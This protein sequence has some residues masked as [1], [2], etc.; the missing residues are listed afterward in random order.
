MEY[1]VELSFRARQELMEAWKWYES[2]QQ[3]LGNR[4]ETEVYN[5][6]EAIQQY[7][8]RFPE[9]IQF[10]REKHIR[11]FPYLIIYRVI[12]ENNI[13]LISSIFHTRRNPETKG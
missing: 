6:I 3:G 13:I 11:V 12:D 1:K 10:Y 2:K 5:S 7:P 8:L 4:F 9:K